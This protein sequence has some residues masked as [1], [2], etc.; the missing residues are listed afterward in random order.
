MNLHII[1][2][3]LDVDDSIFEQ[4]RDDDWIGVDYGAL[5]LIEHNIRPIA[6]FGDFDS[7][8]ENERARIENEIEID[9]LPAEKNETDLE[10][11]LQY[12]K[13]LGYQKVFIHGA[14]GGRLDHFLG[15]LQTL[16]HPE[17]LLSQSEFIMV[18]D[19]N[20]IQVLAAGTHIIEKE[21]DKKY[22][23]FIPVNDGVI[24]TLEGF[25]YD[26]ERFEVNLGI[27]RTVS[28]EFQSTRAEVTVEQGMVYIIQSK[29]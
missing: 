6:V 7:I 12:A 17:V 13:D 19:Q 24:L 2:T 3:K 10:V 29:E 21:Y 11:A 9:Y 20:T 18:N 5:M 15:N 28:N 16:L 8:D 22:I 27:T 23:S 26:V 14:T 25:K 1:C 4:Y